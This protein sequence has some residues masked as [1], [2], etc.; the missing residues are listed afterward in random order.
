M[1]LAIVINAASGTAKREGPERLAEL[2]R[3]AVN[4][5]RSE[6]ADIRVVPP[7]QLPQALQ[8]TTTS[9]EE[10]WVGGGDGTLRSAAELIMRRKGILGVLPLGTMNLLA[11]DLSIPLEI[12]RAVESIARAPVDAIDVGQIN[13]GI[14]LNKSALGLYPEM[15][16][17]RERRRRLMGL[18]KWPAMM[19]AAWRA[20]R[21]HRQLEITVDYRGVRRQIVSPALIVAVGPYEFRAGRLFGRTD[22]QSG[23]LS[24]YVS[25]E[26]TTLGSAGQLAKLFL[27]TLQD[28]AELET[29]RAE[30]ITIDFPRPKP[31]ANDGE[32]DMLSGPIHY[33]VAPRA[34]KVRRPGEG[35]EG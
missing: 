14:F 24:L 29:I 9:H 26:R 34:L 15:I 7:D 3:G 6:N 31:I 2:I 20:L 33:A 35:T 23:E 30:R 11:R 27:G 4:K 25:H 22:L 16:I 21:R 8:E 28:D 5:S 1:S 18:E 12:E 10:V 13:D 19:K 32:V 17:D